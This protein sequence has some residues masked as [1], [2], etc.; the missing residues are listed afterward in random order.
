MSMRYLFKGVDGVPGDVVEKAA[1]TASKRGGF[2]VAGGGVFLT[3]GSSPAVQ[4]I[5]ESVEESLGGS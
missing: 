4:R 1:K 2:V 5:F 3:N